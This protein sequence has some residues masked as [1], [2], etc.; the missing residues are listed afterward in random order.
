L[1]EAAVVADLDEPSYVHGV[2]GAAGLSRWKCLVRRSSLFG[3]WEAVEFAWLPPAGVSGEHL[4]SRTEELYFIVFGTGV[5]TID[6]KNHP[7]GAGD[8]VLTGL[9]TVHGLRNTGR[10][11]LGWLV[12]EVLGPAATAALSGFRQ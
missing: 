3:P 11:E 5:M 1:T 9:G 8:L 4:H 6:G 12:I 10:H 7:V 2:H